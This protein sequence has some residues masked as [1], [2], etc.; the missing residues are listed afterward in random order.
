VN[1]TVLRFEKDQLDG[2]TDNDE[3]ED[4]FFIDL[5]FSEFRL[6]REEAK[7]ESTVGTHEGDVNDMWNSIV[8]WM[9]KPSKVTKDVSPTTPHPHE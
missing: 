4:H 7:D 9:K 1:D 5:I 8:K 6:Q 2:A 3:F